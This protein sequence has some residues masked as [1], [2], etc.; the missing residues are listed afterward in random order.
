MA[1]L[2]CHH[3]I[4]I[5]WRKSPARPSAPLSICHMMVRG[6]AEAAGGCWRLL[7]AD[8]GCKDAANLHNN[9]TKNAHSARVD[10][11]RVRSGS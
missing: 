3:K 7:E 6:L 11:T 8:R 9:K 2:K 4:N 1:P 5:P 10:G